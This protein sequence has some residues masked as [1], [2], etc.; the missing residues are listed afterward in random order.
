MELLG[1]S[2]RG[3]VN[4]LLFEI[5]YHREA[6]GLLHRLISRVP[7][8]SAS[9]CQEP[10]TGARILLEQSLSD[11]G[12]ADA[13]ILLNH[14]S[15]TSA[16]FLE[17]KVKGSSR[18]SWRMQDEFAAFEL[19]WASRVNS[20]NLFA[21]LYSKARFAWAAQEGGMERLSKGVLFPVCS[22]KCRRRIGSNPVV[23]RA[24]GLI[25]DHIQN[26]SFVGIVPEQSESVASFVNG[27]LARVTPP[28]FEGWD[29]SPWGFLSWHD[30]EEFCMSERL[31]N[32]LRVLEFNK[33]QM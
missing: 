24:V 29:V 18:A 32:T 9:A 26:V 19:G 1:Y 12:D 27:S 25:M 3:A 13:I 7:F 21:Q 5:A 10:I 8:A 22:T 33:E 14:A 31:V 11:F 15:T 30:I 2:E 20:S 28:S 4:A 17:A 6:L 23:L 16:L